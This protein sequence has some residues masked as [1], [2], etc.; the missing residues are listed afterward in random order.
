MNS[1]LNYNNLKDFSSIESSPG[2]IS[3]LT[4]RPIRPRVL[5]VSSVIPK[6]GSGGG[7]MA[8]YRHFVLN[9]DFEVA[10]G[11]A[12][13][14][15]STTYPTH[16]IR[17]DRYTERIRRTRLRRLSTNCDSMRNWLLIPKSLRMFAEKFDPDV[18]FSVVDDWHMGLAWRLSRVLK[19][20]LAVN[21]QDLFALSMFQVRPERPYSGVRQFLLRRYRFLNRNAEVVFHTS[22][23]MKGWFGKEARGDVLYPLGDAS[24]LSILPRR[25]LWSRHKPVRLVYA[26]NCYGPY[27]RMLLRLANSTL[28]DQRV[29]LRIFASGNDWC[30]DDLSKF[31]AAGI[32][33][34]FRPFDELKV[35]LEK[36]DAFLTVMSFESNAQNFMKTSFTTKWLDYAPFAKPVFVW[37]PD[38]STA[39]QFA[40]KHNAGE[41]INDNDPLSVVQ[42][43]V[44]C[45]LCTERWKVLSNCAIAAAEGPLNAAAI[46]NLL[47]KRLYEVVNRD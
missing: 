5:I 35:E 15:Q 3:Q 40:A 9:N 47:K 23:G 14:D 29:E 22:E 30:A 41:V 37:G 25:P 18:V 4:Q 6:E 36:A 42:A 13:D 38:Y 34:G 33:Q 46:H 17:L 20:P 28:R 26:G 7:C 21:F 16:H 24:S 10:V 44:N 11:S 43:V 45:S 32:Y 27:G 31:T 1:M 12:R 8:M 39:S 19:K 2:R